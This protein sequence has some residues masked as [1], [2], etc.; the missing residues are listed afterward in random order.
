[1]KRFLISF[2]ALMLS[3][4]ASDLMA[5]QGDPQ[6]GR[7]KTT[8]CQACHGQTGNAS[9]PLFANLAGQGQT[10]LFNQLQDIKAGERN[11]PEMSGMLDNF[12]EQDLADIAAFY[13]EQSVQITGAELI[14]SEPHDMSG[15]EVLA[16]GEQIYRNGIPDADVPACAAC[17]SPTGAGNAPAG[18][19]RLGGQHM[20]YIVKQLEDFRSNVRTNDGETAMM[21]DTAHRMTDLE[22]KAVANYISGLN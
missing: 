12:D 22:I 2:C 13:A 17:H 19:P 21:R 9:S 7:D 4:G 15:E 1:M 6:A 11:I 5:Q 10:Y 16:L 3:L 20:E 8:N 14:P 18:Y